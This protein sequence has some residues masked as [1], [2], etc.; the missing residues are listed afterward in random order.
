MARNL[1]RVCV[2]ASLSL[3]AVIGILGCGSGGQHDGWRPFN[4]AQS[5][6]AEDLRAAVEGLQAYDLFTSG[7]IEIDQKAAARVQLVERLGDGDRSIVGWT[8]Q[9]RSATTFF[10]AQENEASC[11]A[12]AVNMVRSIRGA[13]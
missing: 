5:N 11:T 9:V 3:I 7:P 4:R 8:V 1:G 6:A 12:A 2:L 13:L 10:E